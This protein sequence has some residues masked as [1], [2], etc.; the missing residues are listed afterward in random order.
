MAQ[1]IFILLHRTATAVIPL[2]TL[3]PHKRYLVRNGLYSGTDKV[4]TRDM[5]PDKRRI[6]GGQTDA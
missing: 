4:Q 2:A 6:T 5:M 1:F 3:C